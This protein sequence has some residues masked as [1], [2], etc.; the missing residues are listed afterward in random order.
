MSIQIDTASGTKEEV[1][2]ARRLEEILAGHDLRRVTYTDRVLVDAEATVSHRHPVLTLAPAHVLRFPTDVT[3]TVFVHEQMHWAANTLANIPAAIDEARRRWPNPPDRARGGAHS[4][5]STWLHFAVC[6]LEISAMTDILGAERALAAIGAV[7]WYRWIYDQLLS[8]AFPWRDLI[9]R[10]NLEL[11]AEPPAER[12]PRHSWIHA[13]DP[14]QLREAVG[15]LVE[16]FAATGLDEVLIARVVAT[17]CLTLGDHPDDAERFDPMNADDVYP[18][19]RQR[20]P[21]VRS[22]I[23]HLRDL[24]RA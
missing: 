24:R 20:M 15:A 2:A 6:A 23:D 19:L 3:L 17:C 14:A 7:P 21:E 4:E 18:V 12:D 11:P 10:W 16:P 8:D 9:D 5:R 13:A 22:A 1:T